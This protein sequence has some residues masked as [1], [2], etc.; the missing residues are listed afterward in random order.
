MSDRRAMRIHA[1]LV[2]VGVLVSLVLLT[3]R[4]GAAV[5]DFSISASPTAV[6]V[7]SGMSGNSTISTAVT[8]GSAQSVALS[9]TGLPA[10]STGTLSP[11]SV[12]AGGSST[13]TLSS[14]TAAP[15][16]Y[17]V[18]ITGTGASATH[19][20]TVRFTINPV[21]PDDFSISASPT[22]VEVE[23]G[24]SGNSTI[25]TAVT[26]G[27]AQTVVL[28]VTG[29]PAGSTGTLSPT[30]VT[31]GGSSTLTLNSGTAAPGTYSVTITGTGA[32]ATHTTTVRFTINPVSPCSSAV[33]KG[34]FGKA[35]VVG[36][37][38]VQ[39]ELDTSLEG[40]QHLHVHYIEESGKLAF[41]LLKLEQAT[42]SGVQGERVFSGSG[43][44]AKGKEKGY[45]FSF[46]LR[47]EAGGF[48][49]QG[50]L[51]KGSLLVEPM[52]GPLKTTSEK[53]G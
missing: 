50:E 29:L 1:A 17:S 34:T 45:T 51:T 3:A 35:G 14:G 10:G 41:R 22:A 19:A 7:E 6:E 15:G 53:I 4:A 16:T 26:S 21:R 2:V 48:Y 18:T 11:T 23:S 32:S 5:D 13:L 20:T 31:A 33:G 43:P 38:Q 40:R 27:S 46:S 37:L 24:M 12:T 9:V 42:C 8:S 28:S 47:E 49:F 25:S 44:A 52:G 30:S 39:N 36:R